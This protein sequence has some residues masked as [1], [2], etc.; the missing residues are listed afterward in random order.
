MNHGLQTKLRIS[1]SQW[2]KNNLGSVNEPIFF[3]VDLAESAKWFAIMLILYEN[4]CYFVPTM[5]L[6][7]PL[8]IEQLTLNNV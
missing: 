3:K 7:I 4:R 1:K 8:G 6:Q 2:K 5:W